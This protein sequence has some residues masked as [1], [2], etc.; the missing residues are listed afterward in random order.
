MKS[1]RASLISAWHSIAS[2]WWATEGALTPRRLDVDALGNVL[3]WLLPPH[4]FGEVRVIG[5]R[6]ATTHCHLQWGPRVAEPCKSLINRLRHREVETL[7]SEGGAHHLADAQQLSDADL[8][9][10]EA[11]LRGTGFLLEQR[12]YETFLTQGHNA[13]L[14]SLWIDSETGKSRE[15]D[16]L[17]RDG[18]RLPWITLWSSVVVECKAWS[19]PIVVIGRSGKEYRRPRAFAE[20]R[21]AKDPLTS[22]DNAARL[23]GY[24]G[25]APTWLG[26]RHLSANV[27]S[28]G[29]IGTQMV[30]LE[31]KNGSFRADNSGVFAST[32]EPLAK[33]I[34]AEQRALAPDDHPA[35]QPALVLSFPAVVTS[36]PIIEAEPGG[37]GLVLR[38][39]DR[40]RIFRQFRSDYQPSSLIVDVVHES[41]V[42]SWLTDRVS[43]F[44]NQVKDRLHEASDLL[45]KP[46]HE[47]DRAEMVLRAKQW[48]DRGSAVS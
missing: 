24:V 23:G 10:V 37:N 25:D 44:T 27:E 31:R 19:Q 2:A 32:I 4:A 20:A 33:A 47:L 22:A 16:V 21:F 36:G 11:G 8:A 14:G 34:F 9:S 7:D 29:F 35:D 42:G 39:V 40:T 15:S 38:E 48:R 30:L 46:G 18:E 26:L 17:A 28:P 6:P 41:A 12:V 45:A 5:V 13:F 1:R 3:S 43:A